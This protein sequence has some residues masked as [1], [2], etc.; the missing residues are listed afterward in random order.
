MYGYTCTPTKVY[1]HPE[2]TVQTYA[3]FLG[4]T[5]ATLDGYL[6]GDGSHPGAMNNAKWNW[7]PAYTA[8]NGLNPYIRLGFQ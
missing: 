7:N 4:I 2:R 1:A 3:G 8:N 6:Y 5:P